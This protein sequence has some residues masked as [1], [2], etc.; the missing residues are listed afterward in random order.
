MFVCVASF[1]HV[2]SMLV[3]EHGVHELSCSGAC[4]HKCMHVCDHVHAHM[5]YVCVCELCVCTHAMFMVCVSCACGGKVQ[6]RPW[7]LC[8]HWGGG[9]AGG[10][11]LGYGI[12]RTGG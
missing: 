9:K 12:P 4:A 7:N 10:K 1:V 11:A 2:V 5:Q 8:T 6:R 3:Y